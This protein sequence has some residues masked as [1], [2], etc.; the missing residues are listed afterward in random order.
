MERFLTWWQESRGNMEGIIR[1]ALAHFWFVTIHPFDG[2]QR[3][4]GTRPDRY[5]PFPG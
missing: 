1:A 5:G 3:T 2:W 4:T